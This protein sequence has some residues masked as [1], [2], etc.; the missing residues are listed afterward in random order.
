[1]MRMKVKPQICGQNKADDLQNVGD[2]IKLRAFE[3]GLMNRPGVAFCFACGFLGEIALKGFTAKQIRHKKILM[4]YSRLL[5][6][7]NR[8]FRMYNDLP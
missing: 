2:E 8:V 1:M 3:V 5:G 6:F 4:P 7:S